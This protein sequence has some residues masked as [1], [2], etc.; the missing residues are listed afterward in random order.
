ML[1]MLPTGG[2]KLQLRHRNIPVLFS[3]R[4]QKLEVEL[5]LFSQERCVCGKKVR[6][7]CGTT[8]D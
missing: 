8:D 4:E 7:G 6:S 1:L 2:N 3:A 5:V